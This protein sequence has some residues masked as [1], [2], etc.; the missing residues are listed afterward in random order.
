MQYVTCIR[1][2]I[3]QALLLYITVID[4]W[5]FM[6]F[7]PN[8]YAK[9]TAKATR[10]VHLPGCWSNVAP[11]LLKQWTIEQAATSEADP[12]GAAPTPIDTAPIDTSRRLPY[13]GC[14]TQSI[15]CSF[16]P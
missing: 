8:K 1:H 4:I 6:F 14:D 12:V 2:S 10:T 15:D 5:V 3:G 11:Y 9:V 7:T 13:A 16:H